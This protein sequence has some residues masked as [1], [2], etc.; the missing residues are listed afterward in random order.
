MGGAVKAARKLR[1]TIP[2]S[3]GALQIEAAEMRSAGA[4]D[5]EVFDMYAR[6]FRAEGSLESADHMAQWAQAKRE[7]NA[8]YRGM[9][10]RSFDGGPAWNALPVYPETVS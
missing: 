4:S 5:A 6:C 7:G 8:G 9:W 3:P 10:G 1:T 2:V